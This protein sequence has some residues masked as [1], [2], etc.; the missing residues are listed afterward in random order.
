MTTVL[1]FETKTDGGLYVAAATR[2]NEQNILVSGSLTGVGGHK[3]SLR[4]VAVNCGV[5]C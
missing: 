4:D 2:Q 5:W 1:E 3:L